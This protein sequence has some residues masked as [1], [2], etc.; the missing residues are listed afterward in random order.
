MKSKAIDIE[1]GEKCVAS[2]AGIDLT[3]PLSENQSSILNDC[4]LAHHIICVRD[5]SLSPPQL[6]AAGNIFGEPQV[7]L[8]GDYRLDAPPEVSVISNYETSA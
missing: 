5:Q 6:V 8:L 2:I 4:F 7:Q 3:K 1:Y